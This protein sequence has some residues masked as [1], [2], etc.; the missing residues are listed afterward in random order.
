[1]YRLNGMDLYLRNNTLCS[2]CPGRYYLT[3]RHSLVFKIQ[4]NSPNGK[5]FGTLSETSNCVGTMWGKF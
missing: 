4:P 5:W 2:Y 1:M 3:I